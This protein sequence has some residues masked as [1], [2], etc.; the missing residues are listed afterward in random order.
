MSLEEAK[1]TNEDKKKVLENSISH[2]D[3]IC[4]NSVV[5]VAFNERTRRKF[6]I[7]PD[8]MIRGFLNGEH[9]LPFKIKNKLWMESIFI[10]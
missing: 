3:G 7:C 10:I 8:E 1:V 5:L 2:H 6:G 4:G 9:S